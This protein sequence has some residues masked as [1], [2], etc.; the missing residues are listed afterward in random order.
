MTS[1]ELIALLVEL[2]ETRLTLIGH[3]VKARGT[4][5]EATLREKLSA[6]EVEM[7]RVRVA[8]KDMS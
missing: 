5:R 2:S 7:A 3:I 4:D 1:A 6:L 8:L